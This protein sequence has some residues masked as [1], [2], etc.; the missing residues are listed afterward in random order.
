M[1]RLPQ[2]CHTFIC[3]RSVISVIVHL[4]TSLAN[5]LKESDALDISLGN[6]IY[7]YAD[8]EAK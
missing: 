6:L 3:C 1:L 7:G 5:V 8:E 2:Y 4:V